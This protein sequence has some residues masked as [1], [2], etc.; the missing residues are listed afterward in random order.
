ML[1]KIWVACLLACLSAIAVVCRYDYSTAPYSQGAVEVWYW[2]MDPADLE[3]GGS[4]WASFLEGNDPDYATD[5]LAE[6]VRC[7]TLPPRS[8]RLCPGFDQL[9]LQLLVAGL[10]QGSD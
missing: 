3:W 5:C 7:A 2:S 1:L 10:S 4:R 6:D 8:T 9:G